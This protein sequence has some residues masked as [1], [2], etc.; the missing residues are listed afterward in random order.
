M[1]GHL[2]FPELSLLP[3]ER[4]QSLVGAERMA[5]VMRTVN[6]V[7]AR[8]SGRAVW[9]VSSS[10]VGGGVA[11]M[12]RSLL[13]YARGA[14]VDARWAVMHGSP[15]F[16][17]LTKRLHNALHGN[18][19]DASALGEPEREL[20]ERVVAENAAELGALVRPRDIV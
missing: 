12:V 9:N 14:G 5:E 19:G 3:L 17:A 16:F 6:G 15:E 10:A 13:A 11:E 4:Y 20:Y 18:P 7:R 8:L 2:L 1:M